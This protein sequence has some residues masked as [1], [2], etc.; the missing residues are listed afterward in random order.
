MLFGP[1][2]V[3]NCLILCLGP[4]SF[5]PRK[6]C[7]LRKYSYLLPAE[8]IGIQSH[9]SDEVDYHISEF[10]DIL[11]VFE[12]WYSCLPSPYPFHQ[13]PPFILVLNY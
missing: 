8:I 10:N 12:V 7:I 2:V 6:E 3:S 5:D 1:V 9:F 13:K 11:N 4:R